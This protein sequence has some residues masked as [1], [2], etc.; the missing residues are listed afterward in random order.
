[1]NK[2]E[3]IKYIEDNLQF[4][5]YAMNEGRLSHESYEVLRKDAKNRIAQIRAERVYKKV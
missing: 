3:R 1:M 2:A 4:S 5:H